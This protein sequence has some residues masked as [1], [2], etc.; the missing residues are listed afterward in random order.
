MRQIVVGFGLEPHE[1]PGILLILDYLTNMA[2]CVEMMLKLLS[3]DWNSHKVGEMYQKVFGAAH[4]NPTLMKE[5]TTAVR[6][7]KY[8]FEPNG[9][10]MA[11]IEDLEKLYDKLKSEVRKKYDAFEVWEEV[12]APPQFTAYLLNNITRFYKKQG[13]SVKVAGN[14]DAG[15]WRADYMD[16]LREESHRELQEIR[17][18]FEKQLR[19]GKPFFFQHNETSI[20]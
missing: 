8:L 9:G 20:V 12:T 15:S 14:P 6:H 11:E 13:P 18:A 10:L 4:P 2:Y 19:E 17:E 1:Y 7:Q 3:D 5:I 16:R